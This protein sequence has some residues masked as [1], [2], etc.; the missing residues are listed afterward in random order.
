MDFMV[1]WVVVVP[2]KGTPDAKSRL[3][4]LPDRAALADA[5]ALDTVAALVA[6]SAVER[7]FVVTGSARLG[8]LLAGI[9]A[10]IVFETPAE[11]EAEAEA[12]PATGH[13]RLNAAIVQGITAAQ[14]TYPDRHLAVM[15]GDLPALRA[16]DV[17][18]ALAYAVKHPRSLV[19]DAEGSGTTA[20]FARAGVELTPRFGFGSR[21]AHERAGH[22]VLEVL[23]TSSM[24]RDVDTA[25][26]LARA[27]ALGLGPHTSALLVAPQR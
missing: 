4:A 8:A 6:V 16:A 11:A 9:G 1:N 19:P 21:A 3:G 15:A 26:D 27:R 17:E 23:T 25:A 14:E 13:I 2:V 22:R 7:V 5:F 10:V 20:L 18:T 24:R 12:G